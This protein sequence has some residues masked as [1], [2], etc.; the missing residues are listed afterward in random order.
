MDRSHRPRGFTLLEL[1]VVVAIVGA[2]AS[3]ATTSYEMSVARAKRTEA[4]SLLSGVN[5]AQQ[6]YFVEHG[7]YAPTFDKLGFEALAGTRLSA[8]ELKGKRYTLQLSQPGGSKSYYCS[9]TSNIDRD[10]WPDVVVT[11]VEQH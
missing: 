9:A 2:I 1:M 3:I 5:A 4:Y 8:T 10:E 11:Q 7:E 6:A